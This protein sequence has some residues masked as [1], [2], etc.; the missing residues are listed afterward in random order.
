M[1][2]VDQALSEYLDYLTDGMGR[3]ERRRS[4]G[5]YLTGLLLEGESKAIVSM[6]RRLVDD[7]RE[8]EAMRQRLQQCIVISDWA[9]EEIR[10]R[11]AAKVERDLAPE[12]FVFDDTG[13]PKKGH[14]SVGVARQY[15]GT[16]GRVDNCQ[17]ATSL[18]VATD[19][20]SVC[21]GMQLYLPEEWAS[22]IA[23]RR[24][25]AVPDDVV[26]KRKW[27]IAIGLLDEALSWGLPPRLALADCG[28]GDSTE[29]RDELSARGCRYLVG[30]SGN[31]LVWPPGSNPRI[32]TPRPGQPGRR[33]T[34]HRDGNRKPRIVAEIAK[35]L[36]Y[37]TYACPDGRGGTKVGRFAFARLK[38]A[39]RRTKGR[40]PSDEVWL[41][42]EH[43]P[44]NNE[45]KFYV[46]DLP[47]T[48]TRRELVRLVKLRW[49]VERDYQ[50]L[51]GEVGL[52]HF[53]GRTWRGFHHHVTLC[54]AAHAFLALQRRLF[55]PED[56]PLEPADGPAAPPAAPD[57]ANRDVPALPASA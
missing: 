32:P 36:E 5:W 55:P 25:A 40:P 41:I 8:V 10:R 4:L 56:L 11:I 21:L 52:D 3:P 29:F 57:R 51:K 12:A 15:S 49:R 38:L 33:A 20:T 16:L 54:A 1:K 24:A 39:E 7:E 53:E 27:E 17:V 50:E 13:F 46:S 47:A 30:L 44:G 45:F 18:H 9:D 34:R 35:A 42:G 31:Q 26:F 14:L 48:T 28:Y 22:D 37:R 6:A 43:R 23:R 19:E 2:R